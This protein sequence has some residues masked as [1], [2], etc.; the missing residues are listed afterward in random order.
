MRRSTWPRPPHAGP[1]TPAS[2]PGPL[3]AG[4]TWNSKRSS[5]KA[6]APYK[7]TVGP[8]CHFFSPGDPFAA[9]GKGRLFLLVLLARTNRD[10]Q[11]DTG[12]GNVEPAVGVAAQVAEINSSTYRGV[13]RIARL[14][15]HEKAATVHLEVSRLGVENQRRGSALQDLRSV[16]DLP[17]LHSRD[18]RL[19]ACW[20]SIHHCSLHRVRK[21]TS[22]KADQGWR[23]VP[24]PDRLP[25]RIRVRPSPRRSAG[26]VGN[27]RESLRGKDLGVEDV[28]V[29]VKLPVC[30][31]SFPYLRR[32]ARLGY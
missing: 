19:V 28:E 9:R 23:N 14:S 6:S 24:Q 7:S 8:I 15:H 16:W 30:P 22:C 32:P 12:G 10:T 13:G 1:L 5:T 2:S 11:S 3:P 18:G 17:G 29:D 21:T 31:A 25:A 4:L 26:L 20:P 27:L